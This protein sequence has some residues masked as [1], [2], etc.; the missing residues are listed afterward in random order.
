[1]LSGSSNN[2]IPRACNRRQRSYSNCKTIQLLTCINWKEAKRSMPEPA[3][4]VLL[5]QG[6]GRTWPLQVLRAMV[7]LL[8]A[9]E[10]DMWCFTFARAQANH[11]EA[12][13]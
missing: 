1:M 2:E 11:R 10:D 5:F 13:A 9:A 3:R 4:G 8:H 7:A 6:C 12:K